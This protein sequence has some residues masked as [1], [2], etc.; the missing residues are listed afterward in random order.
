MIQALLDTVYRQQIEQ[1]DHACIYKLDSR[2]PEARPSEVV[3]I[4]LAAE[5]IGLRRT[6]ELALACH[7]RVVS[8]ILWDPDNPRSIPSE[9]RW[10]KAYRT[11][12]PE[13]AVM[14]FQACNMDLVYMRDPMDEDGNRLIRLDFESVCS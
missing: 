12:L 13:Q 10:P 4:N 9:G 8:L 14:E 11:I 5:Y 3:L 7:A 2:H 1:Y 6:V